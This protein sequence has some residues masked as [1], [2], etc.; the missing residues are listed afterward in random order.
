MWTRL[1]ERLRRDA[2]IFAESLE[3]EGADGWMTALAEARLRTYQA[4]PHKRHL[5]CPYCWIVEGTKSILKPVPGV[6]EAIGCSSCA[7]EYRLEE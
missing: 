4:E 1:A 2:E 6:I 5:E 7:S 3:R